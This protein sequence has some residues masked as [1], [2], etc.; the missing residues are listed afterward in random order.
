MART[1]RWTFLRNSGMVMLALMMAVPVFG[2]HIVDFDDLVAGMNVGPGNSFVSRFVQIDVF[3]VRLALGNQCSPPTHSGAITIVTNPLTPC[4]NVDLPNHGLIDQVMLDFNMAQ[5][6]AQ[7][8]GPIRKLK[9]KH[10]NIA[11]NVF[12]S[13]NGVCVVAPSFA[14]ANG[15]YPAAGVTVKANSCNVVLTADPGVMIS[16]FAVG[17]DVHMVDKFKGIN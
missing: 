14:A 7:A 2:N 16:Q 12:L 10:T 3:A 1:E 11:G 9:F 5:F 4:N 8:G 15:Y 6:A 17:A 13:F